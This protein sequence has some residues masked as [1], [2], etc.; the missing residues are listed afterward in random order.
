MRAAYVGTQLALARVEAA[1]PA[2]GAGREAARRGAARASRA[3]RRRTSISSWPAWSAAA[4]AR[5]RVDATLAAADALARLRLLV[6]LPPAQKLEL[7]A[8]A[9][10]AAAARAE[11]LPALLG[12]AAGAARRAGGAG[13]ERS[14]EID[15]DI[16][17][18]RR[19]AIPSPTLFVGAAARSARA[20]L[21]RRRAGACRC[22]C[23]GGSRASWRW[24]APSA[25]RVEEERTLV[26][27]DVALEVERAFQAEAAQREM[28]QL[29]DR[30]VLPAAEAA[31]DA[32]DR[33]V[34]GR[35]V[36]SVPA[37][38]D[39]ARRRARRGACT[40]KRWVCSG[41]RRSPSIAP[42]GRHEDVE[43]SCCWSSI[44]VPRAD[45]GRR[46]GVA[47]PA[48]VRD[49][50]EAAPTPRRRRRPTAPRPLALAPARAGEEPGQGRRRR[51]WRSW[52]ATSRWS[53]PSP[54]TRT[55]SR[56]SGRWWR[57]GSRGCRAGVGDKVK[58]GQ[59]IAE[60]ESSEVGQARADFVSA[61][62]PLRRGRRQPAARDRPGREED[63]VVARA[64]AGARAVGDRAGG[65]ARGG[66][67]GC[68][69]SA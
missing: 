53:A 15:A 17:R 20:V 49:A 21:R 65:R 25:S 52:R 12:R 41:S 59:V 60:I 3:A 14:D 5:A 27:R 18:L 30:E 48:A 33:G 44:L 38:A 43:R 54:S 39:V 68:A 62:G 69:P 45:R 2:R 40:S 55:T 28:A 57:A 22:R 13:V 58:R 26:E 67:C 34:A 32:D 61:Q 66:R 35:Q 6:G 19:E 56:W 50:A 7:D 8:P 24:R 31:V 63:L 4:R 23:G 9:A 1:T 11:A 64:R 46:A 29:L 37:A 16:T 10:R 42:W 36:R 51:S 47:R